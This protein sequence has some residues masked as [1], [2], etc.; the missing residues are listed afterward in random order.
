M[1]DRM[2][3]D[4]IATFI[5]DLANVIRTRAMDPIALRQLVTDLEEHKQSIAFFVVHAQDS[6]L[7]DLRLDSWKET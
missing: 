7:P 3:I 4:N 5:A 2:V 1:N 6:P